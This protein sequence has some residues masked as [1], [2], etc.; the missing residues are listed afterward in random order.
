MPNQISAA[1]IG[2]STT[3]CQNTHSHRPVS[4]YQASSEPATFWENTK[5][6]E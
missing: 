2:V 6:K 5:R 3:F 4:Q 1:M